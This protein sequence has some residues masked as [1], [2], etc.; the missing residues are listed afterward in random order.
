M[1]GAVAGIII[2]CLLGVCILARCTG[3]VCGY[4]CLGLA[5]CCGLVPLR[6][7][8]RLLSKTDGATPS[9]GGEGEV[10]KKPPSRQHGLSSG[11][12]PPRQGGKALHM[13]GEEEDAEAGLAHQQNPLMAAAMAKSKAAKEKA[14]VAAAVVSGGAVAAASAPAPASRAASAPAS[15]PPELVDEAVV[16]DEPAAAPAPRAAP[17]AAPRSASRAAAATPADPVPTADGGAADVA[18]AEVNDLEEAG[19]A[20][21]VA[22]AAA[23]AEPEPEPTRKPEGTKAAVR[24]ARFSPGPVRVE[25]EVVIARAAVLEDENKRLRAQLAN[26]QAEEENRRLRAQLLGRVLSTAAAA[27]PRASLSGSPSTSRSRMD[28]LE[29]SGGKAPARTHVRFGDTSPATRVVTGVVA[30]R[31]LYA[32]PQAPPVRPPSPEPDWYKDSEGTVWFLDGPGGRVLAHGWRRCED[33]TDV[34]YFH[35]ESGESA[36]EPSYAFED[37]EEENEFLRS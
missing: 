29:S 20:A 13:E 26:I 15:P 1:G 7:R 32:S 34:W 16:E 18:D 14:A 31:A 30:A 19:E 25:E 22:A 35:E 3:D 6:G 23:A 9:K 28:L 12:P 11:A 5:T 36:W 24:A 8:Q 10:V 37:E 33:A 4:S 2:L 27:S 21:P 17:R